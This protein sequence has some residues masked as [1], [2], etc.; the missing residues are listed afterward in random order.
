MTRDP[1]V[2]RVLL[3]VTLTAAGVGVAPLVS[4]VGVNPADGLA[5]LVWLALS[6]FGVIYLAV[7]GLSAAWS[8]ARSAAGLASRETD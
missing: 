8:V 2:R 5:T 7:V 6:L 3:A 4:D 1:F